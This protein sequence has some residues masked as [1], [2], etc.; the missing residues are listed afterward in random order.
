[1]KDDSDNSAISFSKPDPPEAESGR[2]V[3]GTGK[4][5]RRAE[6]AKLL[7]VSKSTLRRMEGEVL[8]PVVGPKNVR[9]FH[10]EE[11]RSVIVTRRAGI[12]AQ[13]GDGEVAAAAFTAFD[14]NVHPV[15]VIKQI[16][17]DPDL[18]EA[19][20]ARWARM[21]GQLVLS[22]ETRSKIQQILIGWDS[23]EIRTAD[24]L[25]AFLQKWMTDESIRTCWDCRQ[26]AA[27]FCRKCAKSWGLQAAQAEI[28]ERRARRL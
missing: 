3:P 19:L 4:L 18:V 8:T 26:E 2:H 7:G 28:G 1:M 17:L 27:C 12:S 25:C 24:D 10:E 16:E 21:R 23:G 11:I 15:D 5:L 20:H 6:A 13:R 14:E 22:S 9:L